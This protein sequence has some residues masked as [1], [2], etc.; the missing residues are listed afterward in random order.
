MLAELVG[1]HLPGQV[2]L[3]DD[4]QR[5]AALVDEDPA[6]GGFGGL[7]LGDG[8]QGH[9]GP[10]PHVSAHQGFQGGLLEELVAHRHQDVALVA[11]R[12]EGLGRDL[13]GV[14]GAQLRLLVD[15]QD[16]GMFLG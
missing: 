15:V 3:L 8:Q 7:G 9:V 14:A 16:P 1:D 12:L 6:G 13:G 10:L 4:V 11:D 5:L 2:D